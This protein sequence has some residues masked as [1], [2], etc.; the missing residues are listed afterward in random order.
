MQSCIDDDELTLRTKD[1]LRHSH[2]LFLLQQQQSAQAAAAAAT[3]A[4]AQQQQQ[5]A[6]QQQ[7]ASNTQAEPTTTSSSTANVHVY[8]YDS[9][10]AKKEAKIAR[11]SANKVKEAKN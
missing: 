8:K 9:K 5:Q 11:R 3:A 1:D 4:A 7:A 10:Q 2:D 6:Y